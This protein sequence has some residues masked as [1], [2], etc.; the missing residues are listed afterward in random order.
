[1]IKLIIITV[2]C[3]FS[4]INCCGPTKHGN[5]TCCVGK[6]KSH[7]TIQEKAIYTCPMHP[8]VQQSTSGKCPKCGMALELKK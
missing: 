5:K 3:A 7:G 4:S 8:E 2:L 6:E 1:M